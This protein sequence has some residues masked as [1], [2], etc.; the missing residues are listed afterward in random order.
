A[1]GRDLVLLDPRGTGRST[2]VLQCQ[3]YDE[4][5]LSILKRNVSVLEELREGYAVLEQCF[6]QLRQAAQ[7]FD[8]DH[9]GTL[10]HAQDVGALLDLLPY[11]QWKLLALPPAPGSGRAGA[12]R[13]RD[14]LA[15]V[16]VVTGD[17]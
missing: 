1:L 2:P 7:P 9:Y 14:R 11:D 17:P 13:G 16:G 3:A 12:A 4:L 15:G 5:S 10:R 6:A 8:P